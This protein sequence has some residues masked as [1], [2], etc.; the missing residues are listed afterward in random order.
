M[1]LCGH[2]NARSLINNFNIFREHLQDAQYDILGIS[3]TWL[4]AGIADNM[5]TVDKYIV[6]RHDRLTRAGGVAV[7]LKEGLNFS[8]IFQECRDYIEQ[9]IWVEVRLQNKSLIVGNVYRPPNG[10]INMFVS[11]LEDILADF[12][13]KFD[14]I[15]IMRDFNIN[16]LNFE[17]NISNLLTDV[18]DTF[19]LK[20]IISEPTRITNTSSSLIDLIFCNF[21]V[22]SSGTRDI[23]ISDHMLVYCNFDISKSES[24]VYNF[25]YR[26]INNIN[27]AQFLNDIENI[28]W[29]IMYRLEDIENKV[30]FF[31]NNILEI[32][33]F[34]APIRKVIGKKKPYQPWITPN[35]RL[36]R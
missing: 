32:L 7:Y 19:N 17:R 11:Y 22:K 34:H 3:E 16:M 9:H 10:D 28:P 20:Q 12:Y 5:V 1:F 25:I 30:D 14:S 18:T 13:T 27:K 35:I 33:N 4:H 2:I 15:I 26:Q 31:T 29:E 8:V 23:E 36:D 21:D 24:Q 6:I